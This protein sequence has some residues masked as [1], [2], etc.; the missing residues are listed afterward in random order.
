MVEMRKKK[1][2]KR[3]DT[4]VPRYPKGKADIWA[5]GF[6]V[7]VWTISLTGK[8]WGVAGQIERK[9]PSLTAI[10]DENVRMGLALG[11]C[12]LVQVESADGIKAWVAMLP[13]RETQRDRCSR[14]K[15]GL[16]LSALAST[17]NQRPEFRHLTCP[18]FGDGPCEQFTKDAVEMIESTWGK[19]S[20]LAFT[21][22]GEHPP[23]SS[24]PT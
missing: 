18:I 11:Q 20:C 8:N 4:G 24:R 15:M 14:E 12:R 10:R 16:A 7:I 1:R 22:E 13:V 6:D 21:Y 3:S 17:M 19:I 9:F 2:K 23:R 5:M